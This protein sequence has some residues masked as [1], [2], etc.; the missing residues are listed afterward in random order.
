M[1]IYFPSRI[2]CKKQSWITSNV[3][4]FSRAVERFGVERYKL[5]ASKVSKCFIDG[6]CLLH[7]GMQGPPKTHIDKMQVMRCNF[8]KCKTK[9]DITLTFLFVCFICFIRVLNSLRVK[10]R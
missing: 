2:T 7:Q 8:E 5:N 3:F 10:N 1:W 9:L 6:M 4:G